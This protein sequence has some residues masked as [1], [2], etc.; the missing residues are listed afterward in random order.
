MINKYK[1]IEYAYKDLLDKENIWL[2]IV[3]KKSKFNR[4]IRKIGRSYLTNTS[5][6]NYF[7]SKGKNMNLYGFNISIY[8]DIVDLTVKVFSNDI[9]YCYTIDEKLV[10]LMFLD[11]EESIE[12][13]KKLGVEENE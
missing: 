10:K 6:G 3:F 4:S 12:K 2:I 9:D 11:K 8:S 5:W 7:K 1:Y 13:L